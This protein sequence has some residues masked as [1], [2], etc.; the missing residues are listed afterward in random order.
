LRLAILGDE[1]IKEQIATAAA[2]ASDCERLTYEVALAAYDPSLLK[3]EFF[4]GEPDLIPIAALGIVRACGGKHGFQFVIED[5]LEHEWASVK[6]E[7]VM[8]AQDV[9][10]KR[11]AP[12]EGGPQLRYYADEVRAWW[13][14]EEGEAFRDK[15]K[16]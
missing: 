5:A 7:A 12:A 4:R 13:K 3:R 16:Q 8:V 2:N 11:W 15:L 1:L 10:G 9:T 6:N 14:S